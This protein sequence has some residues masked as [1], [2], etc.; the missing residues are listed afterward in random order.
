MHF[1]T[2]PILTAILSMG[3]AH[4]HPLGFLTQ[5]TAGGDAVCD[6]PLEDETIAD[7]SRSGASLP[8]DGAVIE[9]I[10]CEECGGN[11]SWGPNG[12]CH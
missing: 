5:V 2:M 1:C 12:I 11:V 3:Q 8:D 7:D 10:P 9:Y 6:A 4:V